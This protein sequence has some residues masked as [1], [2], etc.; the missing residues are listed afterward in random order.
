MPSFVRPIAALLGALTWTTQG[1]AEP[2]PPLD[3]PALISQADL[4][5]VGRG[6]TSRDGSR[7]EH[8]A[9]APDRILKATRPEEG[10]SWSPCHV[11][12]LSIITLRI[13]STLF[14]S[15]VA[16]LSATSPRI[17]TTCR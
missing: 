14:S 3:V 9:L 7:T 5:V 15:S 2:L 11:P 8:V 1:V 10:R 17:H 4:I 6:S 13:T 12:T 16:V